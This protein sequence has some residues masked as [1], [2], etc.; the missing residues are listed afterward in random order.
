MNTIDKRDVASTAKKV[1]ASI[2]SGD[3][4]SAKA[5]LST[6]TDPVAKAT[7]E[8]VL[9]SVAPRTLLSIIAAT[10]VS[11]PYQCEMLTDDLAPFLKK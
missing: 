5:A 3:I 8:L 7:L 6:A 4:A 10:D 9:S 11:D 2:D 1:A